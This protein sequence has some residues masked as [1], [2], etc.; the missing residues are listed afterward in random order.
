MSDIWKLSIMLPS[1]T[2]GHLIWKEKRYELKP[3]REFIYREVRIFSA[4]QKSEVNIV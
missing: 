4:T 2:P 3:G 1:N